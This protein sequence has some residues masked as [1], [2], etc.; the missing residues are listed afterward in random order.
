MVLLVSWP[1]VVCG[2]GAME[3]GCCICD[4]D[5]KVLGITL[6]SSGSRESVVED[7]SGEDEVDEDEDEDSTPGSTE[8]HFNVIARN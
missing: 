6:Y 3:P 5:G 4:R 7:D 8:T 2:N 1:G